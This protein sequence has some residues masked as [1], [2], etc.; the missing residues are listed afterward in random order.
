MLGRDGYREEGLAAGK[1]TR[2]VVLRALNCFAY[3]SN[4]SS[5]NCKATVSNLAHDPYK[6][7]V[8][9]G[10]VWMNLWSFMEENPYGPA[11]IPCRSS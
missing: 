10:P 9:V 6:L 11:A 1:Q 5:I 8:F 4:V 2:V 7:V 3:L